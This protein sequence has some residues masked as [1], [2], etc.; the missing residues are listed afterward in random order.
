MTDPRPRPRAFRLDD[1]RIAVDGRANVAAQ[2]RI[3]SA[4]E[5]EFPPV[6]AYA[7]VKRSAAKRS[8]LSRFAA[9]AAAGLAGLMSL[10]V[11]LWVDRLVRSLFEESTVLGTIA[12]AFAALAGVGILG[13]GWK[14]VAA[15]LRQE[16]IAEL[17][18]EIKEA[19]SAD[20]R[21]RARAL[22]GQL[23][24]LF[25]ERPETAQARREVSEAAA[26]IVDGADLL[27]LAERALLSPLDARVRGEIA[28]A[29]KRASMATALTPRAALDVL[30][31]G[32]Q[33]VYLTRR[34]SQIYGG[35]PGL[36]GFVRVLRAVATHLAVTGGIAAGDGVV[37]QLVGHGLA[38]R[39]SARLG[40]GVVNGL[41]TARVGLA[42]MAACR[43]SPFLARPQPT[44]VEVAPSLLRGRKDRQPA[45]PE[46][47]PSKAADQNGDGGDSDLDRRT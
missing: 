8:V 14:E 16:K 4:P 24:G 3:V 44:L 15:I 42:A 40:E 18:E 46:E 31:V 45:G 37:Q 38:S 2:V 11:W 27:K 43:P 36:F 20:D 6:A 22:A 47:G 25:S 30:F 7:T 5:A 33:I 19:F 41:L 32:A 26:S 9:I 29:A 23:N 39:I 13:L 17:Q 1:E 12:L 34:I 28:S 35:R 21:A 10:S